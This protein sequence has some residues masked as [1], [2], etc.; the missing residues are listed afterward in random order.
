MISSSDESKGTTV[1][2]HPTRF[3]WR[4]MLFL[5]P[6]SMATTSYRWFGTRHIQ[7]FLQL[8]RATMSCGIA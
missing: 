1:T 5:M 6:Q 4:M 8:T 3:S 7:R 2:L